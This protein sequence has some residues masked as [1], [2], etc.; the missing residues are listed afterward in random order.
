MIWLKLAA[1]IIKKVESLWFMILGRLFLNMV[2]SKF[3]KNRWRDGY[4]I[5]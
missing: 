4:Q 5:D 1:K 3:R 2:D